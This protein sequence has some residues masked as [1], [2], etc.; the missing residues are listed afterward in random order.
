MW[1]VSQIVPSHFIVV[2]FLKMKTGRGTYET[3]ITSGAYRLRDL[4]AIKSIRRIIR[5][6]LWNVNSVERPCRS[7]L[8]SLPKLWDS[9]DAIRWGLYRFCID[10][11]CWILR[12][13]ILE[14]KVMSKLLHQVLSLTQTDEIAEQKTKESS[15]AMY[16]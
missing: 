13:K 3:L 11:S 5:K 12:R 16:V 1:T 8:S 4:R 7:T 14:K 6:N 15:H 2:D 9:C 10:I